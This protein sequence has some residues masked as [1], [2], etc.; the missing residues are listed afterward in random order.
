MSEKPKRDESIKKLLVELI[1]SRQVSYWPGLARRV[2]GVKAAVMLSQLLYLWSI[3][4]TQRRGVIYK[5]VGDMEEETGLTQLEQQT[6]RRTLEEQAIITCHLRGIPRIWHYTINLDVLMDILQGVH[7]T[8]LPLNG[9]PNQRENRSMGKRRNVGQFPRAMS[10]GNAAQHSP[11]STPNLN[12]LKTT[13]EI[14]SQITPENTSSSSRGSAAIDDD[15]A[16]P[17][18]LKTDLLKFGIFSEVLPKVRAL[19]TENA[20]TPA[21]VRQIMNRLA[22]RHDAEKAAALLLTRLKNFRGKKAQDDYAHFPREENF[23]TCRR[24]FKVTESNFV[25]YIDGK[26][27]CFDCLT[28]EEYQGVSNA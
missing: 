16:F 6:A 3:E 17:V 4:E 13:R 22:E 21:D 12:D 25:T 11:D 19:M 2:G 10:S 14:T 27:V 7:S 24:C 8:A 15:E 20:I 23:P 18:D 1:S 9:I 28:E 5:S 26:P